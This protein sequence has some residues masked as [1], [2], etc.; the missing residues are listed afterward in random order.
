MILP[1]LRQLQ[2]FTALKDTGSFTK[3]AEQCLVSQPSLS[4]GVQD[5]EHILGAPLLD[6]SRRRLYFTPL[7]LEIYDKAQEILREAR[8]MMARAQ[9]STKPMSG[10]MR[11]SCIPTIAPYLLPK[12]LPALSESYPDLELHLF[13][14]QTDHILKKLEHGETDV[15]LMAFPYAT[16]GLTQHILFSE[17]FLLAVPEGYEPKHHDLTPADLDPGELLLLEDGHCLSGHIKQ[18]CNI[19]S[20]TRRRT[21]S[22]SS[23]VML[24]QMVAGGYGITLVPAMARESVPDHVQVMPFTAP[25]PTRDIGLVWRTGSE[26]AGDFRI[27]GEMIK[28]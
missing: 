12:I 9:S 19:Q 1:T 21:Y 5:L 7:G 10:V 23:L 15:G 20:P 11:L 3:A 14:D 6:R 24:L 25:A 22:A 4:N 16:P 28:S 18:A 17:E 27:L 2:Y 26:M 8:S 13:E